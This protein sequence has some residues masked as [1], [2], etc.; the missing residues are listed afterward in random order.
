MT[1]HSSR[2]L[3]VLGAAVVLSSVAANSLS[4]S[5]CWDALYGDGYCTPPNNNAECG[6]DGGDCCECTCQTQSDDD[7]YSGRCDKEYMACIDPDASCVDDDDVTIELVANCS[8]AGAIGDGI[9]EKGNNN[10]EC[11]TL[12]LETSTPNGKKYPVKKGGFARFRGHDHTP[13]TLFNGFVRVRIN[14]ITP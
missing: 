12:A 6:Y 8:H 3:G 2:L 10:P 9:C 1:K 13:E 11:G 14:K 5:G 7:Y 4:S